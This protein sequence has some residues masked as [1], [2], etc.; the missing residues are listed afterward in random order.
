MPAPGEY[1][2]RFTFC[3]LCVVRTERC[4]ESIA[5]A[6][7]FAWSLDRILYQPGIDWLAFKL[8]TPISRKEMH[9]QV[10]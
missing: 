2:L 5:Y 9:V 7:E 10:W 6:F 3:D 8:I 4:Q 1:Q